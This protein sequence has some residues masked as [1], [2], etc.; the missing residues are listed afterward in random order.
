MDNSLELIED[1]C[2]AP[3]APGFE[4]Q[5]LEVVRKHNASACELSQDSL[6]NLYLSRPD[7]DDQAP[8]VMI[9]AHSDEVGFMV[10][11]IKPNGMLQVV[12]LGG[13]TPEV[14][15]GQKMLVRNLDGKYLTGV[16]G[17]KPPHF[18]PPDQKNQKL[19]L[20]EMTIDLGV[21]EAGQVT[22]EL[23]VGPGAPVVPDSSFSFNPMQGV[24]LGKAFDNRLGCA[25]VLETMRTLM[26]EKLGV[27]PL[28]VISAQEEVGLRGAEVSARKANPKVAI[29][30]EGTPA[31]DTF[32]EPWQIRGACTKGP[33]CAI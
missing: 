14:V 25:A 8:T 16:V 32:S 33:S 4:D 11:F 27:R 29:L 21:S 15:L 30:F 6:R 13:W 31:D 17:A 28:G 19:T 7:D 12:P 22:E 10:Q 3:G 23:K 5:V 26:D 2:N 1:L 18:L 24:M 20:Q 9:E